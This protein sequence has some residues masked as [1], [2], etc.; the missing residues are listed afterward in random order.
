MKF[1]IIDTVNLKTQMVDATFDEACKQAGL[2]RLEVDYGAIVHGINIVVFE[3]GLMQLPPEQR[4]F[5]IG[6][7]LFG[8]NAVLYGS[9]SR[10]ETIDMPSIPAVLFFSNANEV[11]RAIR[12]IRQ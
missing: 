4:Y 8:G 1:V 6:V 9:D 5:Q 7:S 12:N 10:G 3:F 2:N 11:E